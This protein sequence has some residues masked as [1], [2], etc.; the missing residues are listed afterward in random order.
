MCTRPAAEM[1]WVASSPARSADSSDLR[2][3]SRSA[4]TT[5]VSASEPSGIDEVTRDS[6]IRVNS[7]LV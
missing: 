2:Y 5:A 6:R 7:T 4:C 3:H 1:S